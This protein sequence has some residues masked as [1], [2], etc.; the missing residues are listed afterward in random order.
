MNAAFL[1]G[2]REFV[3][4]DIPDPVVPDDGLLMEVKACGVCGSDIRRWKEGPP[5]GVDA[6][7]PGHEVAGQVLAVGK[8]VLGYT[9]GDRLA[10]AP[11]IHCDRCYYCHRGLYNLCDNLRLVG[12][13]PGY[14]G[15]F[16]E[17]MVLTGEILARG[18][19]HHMPDG[20]SYPEGA[21]AET[22]SS[23]LASHHNAGTSLDDV[24]VVMGAGPIGCLHISVAK[25]RGAQVVVSEP[26]ENRRE[27]VQRFEPDAVV[28]PFNE[29]LVA[30]VRDWTDGL[31]ASITVCANPIAATQTQ[32][33]ELTRKAGQIVLFGG[34]PKANPMTTLDG[35]RIHYGE[36]IVVGA[37]SYHPTMHESALNLLHRKVIAAERLITHT[38]P[39]EQVGEAFEKAASGGG[40]KVI[41]T[42]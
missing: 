5:V 13:T 33:V 9:P 29:D 12:I 4:K 30:F 41:V 24:V 21:L 15:G 18:I 7:I 36:Q 37:F 31:G 19:V 2:A 23:V 11:D 28:D 35:N 40:L 25:A 14:P 16:A 32:A 8:D 39:L 22:L 3:V 26:S 6:I 27:I 38:M 42:P 10:I 1:V 20:M 17:K 34:L